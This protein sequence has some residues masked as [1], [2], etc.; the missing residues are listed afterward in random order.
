MAISV[1]T[2]EESVAL[3]G[4]LGLPFALLADPGLKAALA[5]GVAMDGEEIA[6]PAVFVVTRDRRIVYRHVGESITDRPTPDDMLAAIP[7]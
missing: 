2:T 3:A 4:K 6:V 7:G 5:Y 1:D